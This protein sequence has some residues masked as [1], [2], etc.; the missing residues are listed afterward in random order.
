M[1]GF[2]EHE[3]IN[4]KKSHVKNLIAMA[5][6]DDHLHDAEI[7]FVYKIGIKYGLKKKQITT[8]LNEQDHIIAEIPSDPEERLDQ[9]HDLVGM[10]LADGLV[11]MVE[12][13]FCDDMARKM[14]FKT[15]IVHRLIE[16]MKFGKRS[17]DDWQRFKDDALN[18][19]VQ[20]DDE[21]DVQ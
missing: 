1:K 16:F 4:Y 20:N 7:D 3:F 10:M 2:F 5:R 21:K 18:A 14:G 15:E 12:L 13:E 17:F 11:E 8:I 6:I 9:M 19:L